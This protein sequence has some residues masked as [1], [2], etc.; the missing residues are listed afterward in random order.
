MGQFKI[1]DEQLEEAGKNVKV[2][3]K[4]VGDTIRLYRKKEITYRELVT[5]LTDIAESPAELFLMAQSIL[6]ADVTNP[7]AL[8]VMMEMR[9]S[10]EERRK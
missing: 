9:A 8:V 2:N 4:I 7:T 3:G 10:K 5:T 6:F 1:T